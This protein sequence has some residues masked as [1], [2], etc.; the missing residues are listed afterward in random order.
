[1]ASSSDEEQIEEEQ[2]SEEEEENPNIIEEIETKNK[3]LKCFQLK[4][5]IPNFQTQQEPITSPVYD[6]LNSKYSFTVATDSKTSL[7]Q[8][9][10]NI[11]TTEPF[12]FKMNI[13]ILSHLTPIEGDF[14]HQVFD[15]S[16][17]FS[18][19]VGKK[20]AYFN[21][22]RGFL[23]NGALHIRFR[24]IISLVPP[25][26]LTGKH[27]KKLTGYVGLKN[28]GATCY[29]NSL[30]QTLFMTPEFRYEILKWNYNPSING[31]PKDCI[32]LQLQKLFYH[33]QEPIRKKI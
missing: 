10:C 11:E 15:N 17:S 12:E 27:S 28:Q 13:K 30:I 32:P 25:V 29:L 16:F 2:L 14:P 1:M 9:K 33:L 19:D 31:E 23:Y 26:D 18:V 22:K 6:V 4:W 7:V 5:V 21:D 3:K 24:I 8:M 20:R